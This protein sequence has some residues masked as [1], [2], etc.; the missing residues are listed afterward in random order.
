MIYKRLLYPI[1]LVV[2]LLVSL[3]SCAA[4]QPTPDRVATGVAEAKVIAATLTAQP[5]MA[6]PTYTALPIPTKT[7]TPKPTLTPTASE[8]HLP[9]VLSFTPESKTAGTSKDLQLSGRLIET[10]TSSCDFYDHP[11]FHPRGD[12]RVIFHNASYTITGCTTLDEDFLAANTTAMIVRLQNMGATNVQITVP[13]PD[14][15][16]ISNGDETK[17]AHALFLNFGLDILRWSWASEGKGEQ[18]LEIK[19]GNFAELLYLLPK[20]HGENT[21]T[22]PKIGSFTI[23]SANSP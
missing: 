11:E 18:D 17:S 16:I 13:W 12:Y 9:A 10:Y 20:I 19:P 22:L 6:R 5:P 14:E 7:S 3:A 8:T 21:I 15:L 23:H 4:P 1:V 2:L